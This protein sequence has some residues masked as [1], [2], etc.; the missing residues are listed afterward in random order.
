[1]LAPENSPVLVVP[2]RALVTHGANTVVYVEI[3]P[4]RYVRRV[5]TVGPDDGT[6]AVILSGVG[7]TDH[8]VVEGSLFLEGESERAS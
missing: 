7:P 5:V 2:T 8:V 4:G 3:G 1:V 6:T